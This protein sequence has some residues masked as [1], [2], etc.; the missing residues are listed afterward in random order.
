MVMPVGDG[1][2]FSK[3]DQQSDLLFGI[4]LT[5][6]NICYIEF[7]FDRWTDVCPLKDLLSNWDIVRSGFSLENS[8]SNL[9][10]DGVWRWPLDWLSRFPFLAQLHV[11]VLLDDM[12]DVILWR[13]RDGVLRP[14]SQKLKTQ[15]RLR[16]WDVGPSIDFKPANTCPLYDLV[17]GLS[18]ITSDG[19]SEIASK[20]GNPMML[21][22]FTS[23]M[24]N[25][26]WG[27]NSFASAMIEISSDLESKKCRW[28]VAIPNLED[29]CPKVIKQ[30]SKITVKTNTDGFQT[31][32]KRN[33]TGNGKGN[34]VF[35]PKP[36]FVYR[37]VNNRNNVS[38]SKTPNKEGIPT[39]NMFSLLDNEDVKKEK[40]SVHSSGGKNN[41]ISVVYEA[42]GTQIDESDDDDVENVYDETG[43]CEDVIVIA[44]TSQVLHTKIILKADQKVV[45]CSFIYAAKYYIERRQLWESLQMH[46]HCIHDN[47]WVLMGDFNA[48]LNLEDTF[49]SSSA[50]NISMHDFKE[51]E[52]N[53]VQKALDKDPACVSLREEEGV[54]LRAFNEA[55]LDEER[56]LKQKAKLE[57]LRVGDSNS[58]YFHK[59]V[60]ERVSRNRID[61][62][63]DMNNVTHTNNEVPT[64]FV[65]HYMNFLGSSAPVSNLDNR[66]LFSKKN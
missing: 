47:P 7:G 32:R 10:S 60:K 12:D 5:M 21:D 51:H 35:T 53:E 24:C 65:E 16:Q 1:V 40:R 66:G 11:P 58:A 42:A 30:E 46:N 28:F 52:L 44:S 17:P 23:T 59:T 9:I 18:W 39:G 25:E 4:R 33:A 54:Y 37:H 64:A 2:S 29:Q 27:R 3:L 13:D 41:G 8:V 50:I 56:F 36:K 22:S 45:F 19:L 6:V 34:R 61:I 55:T 57:W 62:I 26:S 48:S 14:F 43:L 38:T 63:T 15:D 49:C 31:V 20:I